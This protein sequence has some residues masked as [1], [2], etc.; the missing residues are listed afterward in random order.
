MQ[1]YGKFEICRTFARHFL[2]NVRNLSQLAKKR[3]VVSYDR[4]FFSGA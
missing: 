2:A 1:Q 3:P 4:T